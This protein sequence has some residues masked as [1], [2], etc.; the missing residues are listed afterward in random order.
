M[1]LL[2]ILLPTAIDALLEPEEPEALG[3][4]WTAHE[5]AP[6][7]GQLQHERAVLEVI[8]FRVGNVFWKFATKEVKKTFLG[9]N[10]RAACIGIFKCLLNHLPHDLRIP[11]ALLPCKQVSIFVKHVGAFVPGTDSCAGSFGQIKN[12]VVV[13][14]MD[15]VRAQVNQ[16]AVG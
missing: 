7:L 14:S 11:L 13:S 10:V 6:G 3:G 9:R 16:V 4:H 12:R 5:G 15:P 1:F 8:R 2:F